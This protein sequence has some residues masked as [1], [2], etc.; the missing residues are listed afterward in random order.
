MTQQNAPFLEGKYGWSLGE[1]NWN[2]GMDENLLKFS[3]LFDRNVDGVVA[4]LPAVVNGKA[5]FL[6]T[7]N[8]LY[9]AVSGSY[10]SS[11]TPKWFEF[12]L[13]S[14]GNKYQ[15]NGTTAVLVDS[16][17]QIDSRLD[18]VELTVTGFATFQ[19]DIGNTSNILKGAALVGYRGRN[20][21]VKLSE[22]VSVKDY[23]AVGNGI[24]D[25]TVAIQNALNASLFVHFGSSA[26][27]YKITNKLTLNTGH[28]VY[29]NGA[30][31]TQT[32]SLKEVF[33]FDSK[34]DI[35]ITGFKGVGVGTDFND[36]PSSLAVFAR[37]V[38]SS[39]ITVAKNYL[40]NFSCSGVFLDFAADCQVI[41]NVIIGPGSPVLTPVTSGACYGVVVDGN[42]MLVIGNIISK[43]AQ[44]VA[45]G[46]SKTNNG[47]HNNVIHDIVGQHGIYADS[48]LTNLSITGNNISA[49]AL[50]GIKVQNYDTPATQ[51]D[52]I[53]VSGNTVI[54]TGSHGIAVLST[55]PG[56]P[57]Y[58]IRN[59]TITG[60]TVRNCVEDGLNLSDIVV[61][62]ISGNSIYNTSGDGISLR[63]LNAV[64][65]ISNTIQEA[66]KNGVRES[67][68]CTGCIISN[69]SIKDCSGSLLVGERNG[70]LIQLGDTFVIKGNVIVE[71]GT[72]MQYGIF[73]SG[74]DQASMAVEGNICRGMTDVGARFKSPVEPLLTIS[75]N[76]F[77]GT[78]ASSSNQPFTNQHGRHDRYYI[79][80]TAP[81]SGTWELGD[82]VNVRTPA[83]LGF[84]GYVCI[85][86]GTPGTW[87]P[88]GHIPRIVTGTF[89]P[90]SIANGASTTVTFAAAGTSIG[91]MVTASFSNSLAGVTL[92]GYISAAGSVTA[93]LSNTTGAAVD[94]ASGTFKFYIIKTS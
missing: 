88:F 56:T 5:Y 44:G 78:L 53:T 67:A 75:N 77:S 82:T 93:V 64:E 37:G 59:A 7:D 2:L 87:V 12:V 66:A 42:N 55:A 39:R 70:I 35:Y 38:S 69:N 3:Y 58:K 32:T 65:I 49:T 10:Y 8:R 47:V 19:A 84:I 43:T 28:Q 92:T 31:V 86:A 76:Y 73:I 46:A 17:G 45:V 57:V 36:S 16:P 15:F 81:V 80:T 85:V 41:N 79:S 63:R 60:N 89:D 71:T 54:N 50:I 91:D 90:P 68:A 22:F 20:V 6:T 27:S 33:R 72:K 13:R 29:G 25:D 51:A 11:P 9:F 4:S 48:G 52:N 40:L 94:L 18:A 34:T 23:G 1:S 62:N 24:A 21:T 74:G 30:L 83:I 61:G 26:D 14:S